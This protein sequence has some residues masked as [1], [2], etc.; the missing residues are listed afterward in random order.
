MLLIANVIAK[1]LRR[2]PGKS[3]MNLERLLGI[4]LGV[5]EIVQTATHCSY[6][7]R[8]RLKESNDALNIT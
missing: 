6:K 1:R 2:F 3:Y 5:E 7:D 4:F 8:E